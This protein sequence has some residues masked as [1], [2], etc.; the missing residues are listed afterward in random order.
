[1]FGQGAG[2]FP[3]GSAVLSD[4]TAQLY[5]YRYEYKKLSSS[6]KPVFTNDHRLRVYYRYDTPHD[7]NLLNFTN[8]SKSYYSDG[9]KYVVGEVSLQELHDRA[10]ELR[11]APVFL[12]LY[13]QD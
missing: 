11:N 10:Q 7:L 13:P 1:M 8:I 4:I 2:G 3:T 9:F 5:D 6:H 12:L